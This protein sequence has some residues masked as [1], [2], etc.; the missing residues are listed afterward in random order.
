MPMLISF[1]KLVSTFDGTD[2]L[3]DWSIAL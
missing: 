1:V 2:A 3:E